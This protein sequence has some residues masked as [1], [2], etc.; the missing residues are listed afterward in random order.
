MF[1]KFKSM[2][3]IKNHL[4]IMI[5]IACML[6]ACSKES[7]EEKVPVFDNTITGLWIVTKTTGNID[8]S[9]NDS[10]LVRKDKFNTG[11]DTKVI[12]DPNGSSISIYN[13][14]G[15][16][17]DWI[18]K[19]NSTSE[20]QLTG[21]NGS[22][23]LKKLLDAPDCPE[24]KGITKID[25]DFQTFMTSGDVLFFSKSFFKSNKYFELN[26]EGIGELYFP[27]MPPPQDNSLD[28]NDTL[29]YQ[30]TLLSC[31]SIMFLYKSGVWVKQ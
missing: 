16:Q 31:P 6:G 1:S 15:T 20:F 19:K 8:F 14:L 26:Y 25:N 13:Y 28:E 29:I 17:T 18:I 4:A 7:T 5:A 3:Q 21:A 23:L 27:G 12:I 9:V 30:P 11:F 2:K 10:F 24:I 22:F